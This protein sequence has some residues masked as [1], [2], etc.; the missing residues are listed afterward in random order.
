MSSIGVSS[1]TIAD[2]VLGLLQVVIG[3]LALWQQ[4]QLVEHTV[5]WQ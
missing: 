3:L 4:R 1:D 2:I 5:R